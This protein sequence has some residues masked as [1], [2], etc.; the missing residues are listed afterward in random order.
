MISRA[1]SCVRINQF[2]FR[3]VPFVGRVLVDLDQ[4]VVAVPH[5]PKI[6]LL[7]VPVPL[8]QILVFG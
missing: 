2:A 8:K 4:Q 1:L 6:E 3:S 5:K 7:R